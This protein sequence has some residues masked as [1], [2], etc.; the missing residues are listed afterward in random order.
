MGAVNFPQVALPVSGACKR[1]LHVHQNVPGV[2]RKL[3]EVFS[4]RNLNIAGQYLQTDP[5]L[6]YVVIDVDGEVDETELIAELRAIEGT[7][8]TRFLYPQTIGNC[9]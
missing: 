8:K 2:L 7:L 4:A 9:G 3:N 1:F 5:E 6:G